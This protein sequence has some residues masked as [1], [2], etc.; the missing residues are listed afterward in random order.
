MGPGTA[1]LSAHRLEL[2][3]AKDWGTVE[4]LN[5]AALEYRASDKLLHVAPFAPTATDPNLWL[6]SAWNPGD[7]IFI[8]IVGVDKHRRPSL[9]FDILVT[10]PE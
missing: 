9:S 6:L 2:T 8:S 3:P 7:E 10:I 1:R 5:C 4:A